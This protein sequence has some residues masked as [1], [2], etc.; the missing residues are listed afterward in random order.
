MRVAMSEAK[1][2]AKGR[3]TWLAASAL[4]MVPAL[5]VGIVATANSAAMDAPSGSA[6]RPGGHAT[7]KSRPAGRNAFSQSSGNLGFEK[8]FDFKLGN[9]V[10][11]KLWVSSPASTKS[12]DGLGPLYNA[13]S[14]QRCHLKDGRG[15]TPSGPHPQDNAISFVMRLG[16]PDATGSASAPDPVYGRQLQDFAV[17]G[18][19]PEGRVRITYEE[20]PFS[21][22]SGETTSLRRPTYTIEGLQY[23]PLA[24][25]IALS[26]R[27]APQMIGLGLLEAIPET[28]IIRQAD[29]D[30]ANKDGI[31][32]RVRRHEVAG[33]DR[34]MIGRFG[35]RAG[36][37][38][39][40]EQAADAFANDVGISSALRPGAWG[41]CS[42]A[43]SLCRGAPHGAEEGKHELPQSLLDLVTFYTRQLAVPQ[44]RN[45]NGPAVKRGGDVFSQIGCASCH[46][47]S[48]TTGTAVPDRNLHN[49]VI[50][51]YTDMLLHDMG[52]GLADRLDEAGV[53]GREWR[54]PP[55][56]GIGLTE[57]VSGHTEFLH[58][59]RARSIEE[60]ILWHGGEAARARN[61][62][63]A[64]RPEDRA[65]LIAFVKSL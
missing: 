39:L 16:V 27:I 7:A 15:H 1:T 30:D 26:P 34:P 2:M 56:W 21:Y 51:P 58:D 32:G 41:E 43:Q 37:A 61:G 42:E 63:A 55:L 49:Q 47:P 22:P 18:L 12:S 44:R 19:E 35:W 24:E 62:F 17:Q 36:M 5:S 40:E 53:S 25:G 65:A 10:F 54:T 23:G 45:V 52:D 29:P 33:R 59:G 48:W 28:E 38:T 4:A 9:A 46:T 8:E 57:V 31:S 64:L 50:W 14:C 11:R 60:A 6:L 20:V 13:R 3:V